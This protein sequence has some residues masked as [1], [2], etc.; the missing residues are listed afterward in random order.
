[1]K[2]CVSFVYAMCLCYVFMLTHC[3]GILF[4]G[5]ECLKSHSEIANNIGEGDNFVE[6]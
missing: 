6:F 1:M 5:T 3:T 4:A 2:D